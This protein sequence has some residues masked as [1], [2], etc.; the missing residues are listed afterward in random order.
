[1]ALPDISP[2]LPQFANTQRPQVVNPVM[3]APPPLNPAALQKRE[4]EYVVG[5]DGAFN[6]PMGPNSSALFLDKNMNVLWVV[7]TDQNGSKNL[8][9]GYCIGEEYVPPKPVTLEDLMAEVR[10]MNDRLNKMEEG[11]MNGQPYSKPA[12]QGRPNGANGSAGGGNGSGNGIRKP[13]GSPDG[14]KRPENAASD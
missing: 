11:N 6:A 3:Q 4:V 2:Y 12:G 9:K 13:N 7:A 5:Q 10:S 8:V 14:S 1:M